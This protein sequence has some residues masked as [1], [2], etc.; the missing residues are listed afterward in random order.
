MIREK[1]AKVYKRD[2]NCISV[3]GLK[4]AFGGGSTTG[5]A[6]IYDNL[7]SRKKFDQRHQMARDGVVEKKPKTRRSKKELKTRVN[8]VRGTEKAKVRNSGGAKKK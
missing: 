8:K 6:C 1:L 2:E 3:Y 7:D 5:F 4:V